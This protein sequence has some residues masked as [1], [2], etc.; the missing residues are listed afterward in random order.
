MP[1]YLLKALL[2]IMFSF[3]LLLFTKQIGAADEDCH[4]GKDTKLCMI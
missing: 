2:N 1:E 3:D 4:L